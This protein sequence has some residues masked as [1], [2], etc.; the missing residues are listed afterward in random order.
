MLFGLWSTRKQS[1]SSLKLELLE[2]CFQGEDFS[3]G[4]CEQSRAGEDKAS[5][6]I[7]MLQWSLVGGLIS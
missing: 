5:Q 7:K 6:Q 1:Y 4:V 2:N 3:C